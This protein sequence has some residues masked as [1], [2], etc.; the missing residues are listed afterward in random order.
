[1]FNFVF[2]DNLSDSTAGTVSWKW[3]YWVINKF[4]YISSSSAWELSSSAVAAAGNKISN[5]KIIYHKK[6]SG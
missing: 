6:K 5:A 4:G 1:M 3:F 2:V